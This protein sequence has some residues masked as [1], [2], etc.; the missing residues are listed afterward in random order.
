M[1]MEEKYKETVALYR[2]G[3]ISP[4][5]TQTMSEDFKS[6]SEFYRWAAAR[7]KTDA[8]GNVIDLAPNTIKSWYLNYR[9]EGFDGLKPKGR[10]DRGTSRK[11]SG[12]M[13]DQ[14]IYMKE[15]YPRLPATMIYQKLLENGTIT[16]KDCSLSTITRC[17]SRI[18]TDIKR[19]K[20]KEMRRY[21]KEHINELWCG[22]SSVG[23]YIKV[24]GVKKKT[25]IIALIDDA[26]RFIVGIDIFF[27]DNYINLMSVIKSAVIKY[28]RPKMFNFDNGSNYRCNQMALLAARIGTVINY[29]PPSTPTSKAKIERWFRTLKDHWMAQLN[30]NDYHCLKELRQS[31][32]QYV[33]QYNSTP[34]SSLAGKTPID[35]FFEESNTIVRIPQQQADKMFLLEI[36]RKVS[37]DNVIVIDQLEYEVD[38]K[39]A[40]MKVLL[41]YS[42]DFREVYVVDRESNSL[43]KINIL[44]KTDNSKIV[45]KKMRMVSDDE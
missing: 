17:V 20:T 18:D 11:V 1:K 37:A 2:Y 28:G 25:Y 41:R 8:F 22:D 27:N 10:S 36:E 16:A 21:E 40:G 5:V 3:I 29:N 19:G 44:K 45:K 15:Q 33:Q 42:P 39:Y 6:D 30:Y 26:S 35:R 43:E 14:I 38:Y 13:Y 4:L 24:D 34:H 23:P 12:D 9:K 32:N 7:T 31:L